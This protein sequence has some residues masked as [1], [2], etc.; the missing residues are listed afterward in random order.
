MCT[1][2]T[3]RNV[4]YT[5]GSPCTAS[6][7]RHTPSPGNRGWANGATGPGTSAAKPRWCATAG[8]AD[9]TASENGGLP[10]TAGGWYVS[11]SPNVT[12]GPR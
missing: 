2:S 9:G 12:T 11:H 3:R 7:S 5:A 1:L 4:T 10:P 6:A 8:L